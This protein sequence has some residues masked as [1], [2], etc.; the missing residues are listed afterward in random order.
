MNA[1]K[2]LRVVIVAAGTGGHVFPGLAIAER[3]IQQGIDVHWLGTAQGRA[4]DW[5]EAVG[6]PYHG[7]DMTGLRGKGI[8]GWLALPWRLARAVWQARRWLQMR[9][10]DFVL[11]MG[12]YVSAP[13]GLAARWLGISLW[14]HEQNAVAGLSN[15]LLAPFC[16]RIWLGM[17]LAHTPMGWRQAVWIGNPLRAQL[18]RSA[19]RVRGASE[20]L[21]VLVIGGSQGARFFNQQLP[22][23]FARLQQQALEIRHQTGKDGVDTVQAAYQSLSLSATVVA[24]IKDMSLAYTWADVV[25]ARAGAL[26]VAE[27]QQVARPAFLV[28]FP[29]SVDDHQYHN[30]MTL[31]KQ[32]IATLVR[33]SDINLPGQLIAWLQNTAQQQTQTNSF[34][35]QQLS[36]L[37][38]NK[39]TQL[40]VEAMAQ[41]SV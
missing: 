3:L 23:I 33:Q 26:T 16:Q 15:R 22:E 40:L 5:V 14:L 25:I 36:S 18:R 35:R 34:L 39:A 9:Q 17:P 38:E 30:A 21:R 13:A 28:P 7:I 27:L 19:W 37:P 12:G 2:N 24:F 6:V 32:G 20:P 41:E 8:F 31:V 4:R 10:P 11:V 29:A 1:K